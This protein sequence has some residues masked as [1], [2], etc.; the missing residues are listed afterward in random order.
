MIHIIEE[1]IKSHPFG[2]ALGL[3]AIYW[4]FK[5]HI[6]ATPKDLIDNKTTCK[7][8]IKEALKS[9][10]VF[11]TPEELQQ[12]IQSVRTDVERR[13]LSVEVFKEFRRSIENQFKTVFARFDDGSKQMERLGE[14]IDEIKNFLMR[15][16]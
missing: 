6:F 7:N 14:S 4:V 9:E 3:Y 12:A 15:E 11:V 2:I 5:N 1:G 16:K 13:F 10:K 8:E